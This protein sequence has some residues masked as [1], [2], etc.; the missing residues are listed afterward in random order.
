MSTGKGLGDK[1]EIPSG[2]QELVRQIVEAASSDSTDVGAKIRSL[3]T[4]LV[5]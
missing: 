1:D 3:D 2:E 4:G 5:S